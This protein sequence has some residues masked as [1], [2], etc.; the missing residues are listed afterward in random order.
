MVN[1]A[2]DD[3][4]AVVERFASPKIRY[5]CH[6][7]NKGLAASRNTGIRAARGKYI[8]YLDDDD[9]FFPDHLETLVT[10]LEGEHLDVAYTDA[11]KDVQQSKGTAM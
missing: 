11:Y 9:I 3:V 1:D 5:L 4:R 10:A 7:T 2:G 6:E 8:A